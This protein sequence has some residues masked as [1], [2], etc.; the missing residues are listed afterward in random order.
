MKRLARL[1]DTARLRAQRWDALV[2][3]SGISALVAAARLGSAG[4]RVLVVEEAAARALHPALREPFFLAG[5]RDDGVLDACIR[6]LSIPLLDRRRLEAE[7]LA[8]QV[9]GPDLRLDVGGTELTREEL[10]RWGLCGPDEAADLVRT[11]AEASEAERNVMRA[12]PL[13]RVGRRL[14]RGRAG[15][16]GS[17]IRGL[18]AE[19]AHPGEA[20][21]P[22]L[23]AQV[24][25][26]SNTAT[27]GAGPA[28]RV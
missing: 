17:H 13:V 25:A 2:L 19:V 14:V 18:P 9:T 27:G 24:A 23:D 22:A 16:T 26:L 4:H 12:S 20:L 15:A 7:R 11:L 3:G 6:E 28:G 10:V 1:A 5:S 21:A 8:Y